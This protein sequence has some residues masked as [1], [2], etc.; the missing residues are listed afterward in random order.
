MKLIF[1]NIIE[2]TYSP[3]ILKNLNFILAKKY[4]SG[5]FENTFEEECGFQNVTVA[6][7][8]DEYS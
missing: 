2:N 1:S 8:V 7:R 4:L 3:L 6:S 5:I